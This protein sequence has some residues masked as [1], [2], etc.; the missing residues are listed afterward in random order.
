M[1]LVKVKYDSTVVM[2]LFPSLGI[3]ITLWRCC[4]R[5]VCE[6]GKLMKMSSTK[7]KIFCLKTFLVV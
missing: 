1:P 4:K 5:N 3:M 6:G 2:G 7:S